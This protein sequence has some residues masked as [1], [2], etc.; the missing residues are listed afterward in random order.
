MSDYTNDSTREIRWLAVPYTRGV[1]LDMGC[2]AERLRRDAIGVDVKLVQNGATI[3]GAIHQ[4]P[5]CFAE[6]AL[7]YVF[8]SRRMGGEHIPDAA[9]SFWKVIRPGACLVVYQPE[10]DAQLW[11]AAIRQCAVGATQM[12]DEISPDGASRFLVW[13][14]ESTPGWREEMPFKRHDQPRALVVR[15][16]GYG[17][18]LQASAVFPGLKRQGY[19]VWMQTVP[20]GQEVLRHNPFI[21]GWW[22]QDP[23]QVPDADLREY[24]QALEGRFDKV[25]NLSESVEWTTLVH[26]HRRAFHWPPEARRYLFDGLNYQELIHRIAGVPGPYDVTFFST[27]EEQAWARQ[28]KIDLAGSQVILWVLAG[29]AF[30]KAWPWTPNVAARILNEWPE[31]VIVTVGSRNCQILEEDLPQDPRIVRRSGVWSIRETMAFAQTATV[32]VG[33][34]TGVLNAVGTSDGPCKV[35]LLSH[36]SRAN[37]AKHWKRTIALEPTGVPCFPCHQLHYGK[38]T[39]IENADTGAAQCATRIG[40]EAV[41]QAIGRS[42]KHDAQRGRGPGGHAGRKYGF[43]RGKNHRRNAVGS[44]RIGTASNPALVLDL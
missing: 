4:A 9:A 17:D 44:E 8:T 10:E 5:A 43:E 19:E 21:D 28:Q 13:R 6:N 32:V 27:P 11:Q 40:P 12:E 7:D 2:G 37:L 23:M 33:P 41:H 42:L 3:V 22:V 16:G 26:E 31:A 24:W 20:I 38:E 25:I 14:K 34:E 36:S 15:Y 35:L 29:S 1:G 30:H 18:Q 39:C